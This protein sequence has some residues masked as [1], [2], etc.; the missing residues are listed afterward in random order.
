[1]KFAACLLLSVLLCGNL[2][3]T[4]KVPGYRL[5]P[6]EVVALLD[7]VE[8]PRAVESPDGR[9]I[10]L[11]EQSAN[12]SIADISRP[13][14]G[15]AGDRIDPATNAPW[16]ES[17]YRGLIIREV[18][19]RVDR[20][21]A[22]PAGAR[23][24]D[25]SWSHTSKRFAVTIA[26]D[27]GLQ[28]WIGDVEQT[29]IR[30]MADRLNAMFGDAFSWTPDGNGILA[31]V[32]PDDR[33]EAPRPPAVPTG[34]NVQE[35]AGTKS[36]VRTFQDLLQT[37][38]DEQLFEFYGLAQLVSIELA[39]GKTTPLGKPGLR[40]QVSLSPD[41]QHVLVSTIHRP[42]SYLL[43]A[44]RFPRI[45]E[46]W[47]RTGTVER[48]IADIPLGENIPIEG[49][50]TGPR[51]IQWQAT[52]PASVVWVEA[53]DGG[54]PKRKVE[55]RDR[56]MRLA[57]PFEAS[58]S[59]AA[60]DAE[61]VELLRLPQRATG[62]L[63]MADQNQVLAREY[64]RDRRWTRLLLFRLSEGSKSS[65][66]ED[67]SVNDRYGDPGNILQRV[68]ENGHWI[69]RQD[70]DWIY[71]AGAGGSPE[72]D[73]PFLDRYQV[74]MAKTERLWQCESGVY[75]QVVA[76][77]ASSAGTLPTI[78]TRR[79]SPAE[80]PNLRVR[81]L[82]TGTVTALT[83]FPDP[84][85]QMRGVHQE[86]VKYKRPD[87][88]ELSATLYLPKGYVPGTKL[89]LIVWAYPREYNDPGTAGQVSGSPSRFVRL[90]GA[91]HLVLLT[92]GYA[93]MDSA[94]M[95]VVGDPETMND[96]F[97]DQ[98]IASAK[99]AIDKAVEMG[100]ADRDRVGV[101]GHSYGAFMTANLLAHSDLF[102]AGLARSG[103]YNRT[104]TPFGFQ[105]ERRTIWEA[106]G[107]YMKLSPFFFAHQIREPILFVHGEKD[108]NPGT[109]PMQSERM[110][111]AV[112]GNGGTA[113]LVMLPEENHGY[114]ARESVL[115]VA[116]ETI[117]WFDRYVKAPPTSEPTGGAG[118]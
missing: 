29:Q 30:K 103:A 62:L 67:R 107:A 77:V 92:Q 114:R 32:V 9:W 113:R 63:W 11:L 94:T 55:S 20:R 44:E 38:F 23:I 64:D 17:Y 15:L 31:K 102:R 73:R 41:G 26:T 100:V 37:P 60:R 1:M 8:T 93:I 10:L 87:G 25:V 82:A 75:E 51:N 18:A 118:Q 5:P 81:D 50:P 86:L 28:L 105:S 57:A 117:E 111:Q 106:P 109:F 71:R 101:G 90:R 52:A 96:T 35:T 7:A 74:A 43:P 46:V 70:G 104:L 59:A 65:V 78:F 84:Q 54:D 58:E 16:R 34:P 68:T 27:S 4:E 112:K 79:E 116:A 115:H 6:P 14:I 24:A 22:V 61:P 13:W 40:A 99:A 36:P 91:S 89:P 66:I 72:G 83:D 69:V 47:S 80:P 3:A 97:L 110:Y 19:G 12:P 53:L 88:V 56:W 33:G 49:V 39:T 85:P 76:M 21:I 42:F 45:T 108:S 95:P 98:I 2:G 48:V